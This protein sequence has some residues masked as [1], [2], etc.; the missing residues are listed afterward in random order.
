MEHDFIICTNY[1]KQGLGGIL[2]Q[3]GRVISY[4]SRKFKVHEDN[5]VNHDLELVV[6]LYTLR[7]LETLFDRMEIPT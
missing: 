2:M 7:S 1:S 6:V 5:Y 4:T 3:N